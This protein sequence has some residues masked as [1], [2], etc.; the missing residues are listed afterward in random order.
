MSNNR[1]RAHQ[2]VNQVM[3]RQANMAGHQ[4]PSAR[5]PERATFREMELDDSYFERLAEE[6]ALVFLP[7]PDVR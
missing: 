6:E 7:R 4:R 3:P 1:Q 5:L 2:N